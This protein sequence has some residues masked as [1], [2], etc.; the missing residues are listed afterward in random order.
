MVPNKRGLNKNKRGGGGGV[1][2]LRKKFPNQSS[3][4]ENE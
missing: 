3:F 4:L 1:L 2:F